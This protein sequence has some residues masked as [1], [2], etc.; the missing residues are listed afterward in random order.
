MSEA[1]G[2]A[3]MIDVAS[4][5][6]QSLGHTGQGQHRGRVS[7]LDLDPP[8]T[9]AAFAAV[10]DRALVERAVQW[11]LRAMLAQREGRDSPRLALC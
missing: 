8:C 10:E 9:A 4:S 3:V 11:R 6:G 7:F 1:E 2:S 5:H